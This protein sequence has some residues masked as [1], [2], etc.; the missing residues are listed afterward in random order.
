M[1]TKNTL[2]FTLLVATSSI[3]SCTKNEPTVAAV[4][5]PIVDNAA[6]AA[7]NVSPLL[8]TTLYNYAN[9]TKP[10]YITKDN[11]LGNP[12]VNEKA[13]IGRVLF[14]DK[15]LSVNNTISCSSC[16]KQNFAFS[17]TAIQSNGVLGGLTVRHSMRLVNARFGNELKFFWNERAASLEAQTIMPIQDHLEMGF[18]GL[19]GRGNFTSL[20]TK[21]SGINY[22]KTLFK[23]G[24]G[25]TIINQTRI[26]ESLA[27]FIRSIQSFDS[28]Y[29]IGRAQV[30]ND[31][32]PF[33]NFT[34]TENNGKILFITPPTF[35]ANGNRIGGG[36]GCN[37]CH[38][39]PEF[40]IDPNTR[41]NGVI[42][43]IG[44]AAI[45][46]NDTRAPSL[47]NL[48]K[49]D[50][51]INSPMMHTGQFKTLEAV[52]GH[53][54][55]IP[56]VAANNNLDGRLQTNNVSHKLNLTP[57][58]I[59]AVVAFMKTLAGNAVYTDPKWSNPFINP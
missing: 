24:Y 56:N 22:Y 53:Y 9:Q 45:E 23:T 14:Y 12:I 54:N 34:A 36:L 37:G 8:L 3:T 38:K 42:G 26:Q 29:D 20:L 5:D 31:N 59:T 4:I 47:R 28:K 13:S 10:N 21:L 7:N 6:A 52:L 18:S 17:D 30:N 51:T 1:Y 32:T 11:S 15:N 46:L 33:P 55:A 43:V 40:D 41:N 35:D 44:S 57:T 27:Q 25:D 50:G 2:L 58:E 39:A 19:A 48:T 49:V 16:H